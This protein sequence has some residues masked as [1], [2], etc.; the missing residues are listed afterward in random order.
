MRQTGG[1]VGVIQRECAMVAEMN[2]DM[3]N[4]QESVQRGGIGVRREAAAGERRFN[5]IYVAQNARKEE[6]GR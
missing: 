3:K 4:G 2:A 1:G 6:S 5:V